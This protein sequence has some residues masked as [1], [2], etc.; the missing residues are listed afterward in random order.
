MVSFDGRFWVGLW[1]HLVLPL[2]HWKTHRKECHPLHLLGRLRSAPNTCGSFF[3]SQGVLIRPL[4]Q[5]ETHVGPHSGPALL[6]G[7][8]GEGRRWTR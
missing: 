2:R 1:D 5:E 8:E 7:E 3:H 4:Q 6:G